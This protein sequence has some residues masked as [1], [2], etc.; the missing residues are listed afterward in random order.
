MSL[1]DIVRSNRRG[2]AY[3]AAVRVQEVFNTTHLTDKDLRRVLEGVEL[4]LV[5]QPLPTGTIEIIKP[6]ALI[7]AKDLPRP[8]RRWAM[9]HGLG[10]HIL[11][12]GGDQTA[13]DQIWRWHQ[14]READ[15]FAGFLLFGIFLVD[16]SQ[17]VYDLATRSNIPL[18][19][20]LQWL[21]WLAAS[22]W[23]S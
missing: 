14:E 18:H 15:I 23:C 20:I 17:S 3:E 1:H 12:H 2:V 13:L 22:P 8:E 16:R 7:I 10:H 5:E 9:A 6:G 21:G 11:D 19:H 4:E